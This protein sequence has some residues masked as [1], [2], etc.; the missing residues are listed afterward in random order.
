MGWRVELAAEG[1]VEGAGLAVVDAGLALLV[2]R[3]VLNATLTQVDGAH[4]RQTLHRVVRVAVVV[5]QPFVAWVS[6]P[7]S[8]QM[9]VA[10]SVVDAVAVV[11]VATTPAVQLMLLSSQPVSLFN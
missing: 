6:V 1:D 9:S 10:V 11:H 2:A 3:T 8:R 5:H 4:L 7:V